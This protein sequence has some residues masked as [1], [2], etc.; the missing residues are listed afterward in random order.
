MCN[1]KGRKVQVSLFIG[2][3]YEVQKNPGENKMSTC[4]AESTARW[5]CQERMRNLQQQL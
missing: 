1:N 3:A 2:V 5:H 4:T